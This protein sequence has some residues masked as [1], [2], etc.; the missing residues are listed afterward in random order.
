[1]NTEVKSKIIYI[2]MTSKY[3]MVIF[4]HTACYVETTSG[5]SKAYKNKKKISSAQH[6]AHIQFLHNLYTFR[7]LDLRH[8]QQNFADL[9]CSH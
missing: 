6:K 5:Y 7:K 2:K 8:P 3:Q 1:M 9:F 4:H